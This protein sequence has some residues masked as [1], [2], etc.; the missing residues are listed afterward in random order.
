MHEAVFEDGLTHLARALSHAHQRDEL[1][2]EI[3]GETWEGLRFHRNRPQ[4]VVLRYPDAVRPLLDFDAGRAQRLQRLL[5]QIWP[6][7]VEQDVTAGDRRGHRISA[8]L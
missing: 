8:G 5:Q 1:C 6:G 3:G 4:A 7:A 2:L